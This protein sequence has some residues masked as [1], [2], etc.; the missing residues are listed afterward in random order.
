VIRKGKVVYLSKSIRRIQK[1]LHRHGQSYRGFGAV[2]KG[3]DCYTAEAGSWAVIEG[4]N[5]CNLKAGALS[6]LKGGDRSVMSAGLESVIIGGRNSQLTGGFRSILSGGV[7]S[8]LLWETRTIDTGGALVYGE[9]EK[10]IISDDEAGKMY[11]IKN[12]V[13]SIST[14]PNLYPKWWSCWDYL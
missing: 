3:G 10:E 7:G 4:G 11:R 13:V 2:L 9:I 1:W 6:H 12:N 8:K 5:D 14:S